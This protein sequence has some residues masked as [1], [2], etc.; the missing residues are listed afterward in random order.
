[1]LDT[2]FAPLGLRVLAGQPGPYESSWSAALV[3]FFRLARDVLDQT[4][5]EA[6]AGRLR[7]P[8]FLHGAAGMHGLSAVLDSLTTGIDVDYPIELRSPFEETDSIAGAIWS[9]RSL[10]GDG[11]E[12]GLAKL[13]FSAGTLDLPLHIHAQSDRFIAAVAGAGRFFWS[14]QPFE[15]FD[16]GDIHAVPV[17]PGDVLIFTRG[18]LHTFSAPD[19][20][21]TLLSYHSPEIPFDDPR[22]YTLPAVRWTPRE[23]PEH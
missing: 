16:G 7:T 5:A 12:D 13:C 19:E 3:Q 14:T 20:D 23:T 9:G 11:C 6:R 18:L 8:T 1:M 2:A 15:R 17:R 4:R 10:L 21:L 22:Q